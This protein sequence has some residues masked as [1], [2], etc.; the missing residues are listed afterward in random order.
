MGLRGLGW[1]QGPLCPQNSAQ[2]AQQDLALAHMASPRPMVT[3]PRK[4]LVPGAA[5]LWQGPVHVPWGV[6]GSDKKVPGGGAALCQGGSGAE[7]ACFLSTLGGSLQRMGQGDLG[8]WS[9]VYIPACWAYT[10]MP[11]ARHPA[12]ALCPRCCLPPACP[13]LPLPAHSRAM[14]EPR[15]RPLTLGSSAGA[16]SLLPQPP[17]AM[18]TVSGL[19]R[20]WVLRQNCSGPPQLFSLTDPWVPPCAHRRCPPASPASSAPDPGAG[21]MGH[22]VAGVRGGV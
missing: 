15:A 22:W 20:G 7:A 19:P 1:P 18:V 17:V 14:P 6:L 10:R 4:S 21:T 11:A 12:H 2:M 13:F 9:L 16:P 8:S 3:L 5:R